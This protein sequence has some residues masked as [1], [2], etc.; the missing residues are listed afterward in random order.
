L[1]ALFITVSGLNMRLNKII[2]ENVKSFREK[3]EIDF[4]QDVNIFIGPNGGGK[5]NLMNTLYW[6]LNSRFYSPY[7][8]QVQGERAVLQVQNYGDSAPE[9]H[10]SAYDKPSYVWI[11]FLA[12]EEDVEG[13]REIYRNKDA[14]KEKF[15]DMLFWEGNQHID[16]SEVVLEY[17]KGVVDPD[18]YNMEAGDK[19]RYKISIIRE[20]R[21]QAILVA[22]DE[23]DAPIEHDRSKLYDAYLRYL[24]DSE[25]RKKLKNDKDEINLPYILFPPTRS[26]HDLSVNLSGGHNFSSMTQSY[27]AELH[28]LVLSGGGSAQILSQIASTVI[29]VKLLE[30]VYEGGLDYAIEKF[31][32]SDEFRELSEQLSVFGFKWILQSTNK[33]ANQFQILIAKM[34]EDGFFSVLQASSGEK[35]LLNFV[36]GLSSASVQN[37]LIIIDEPELNLHPRWQKLLLRFFLQ[38]QKKRN[39]Q[40]ILSTHSASFLDDTTLPHVRRIYRRDQSSALSSPHQNKDDGFSLLEAVK[41]LNAQQNERIF[42]TQKAIL[43]E[44]QSDFVV[45]QKLINSILEVFGV[46]EIIEVIEVLGSSNFQKYRSFLNLLEIENYIVADQDYVTMIGNDEVRRIFSKFFQE[47]KACQSILKNHSLDKMQ[48][49]SAIENAVENGDAETLSA[50]LEYLKCRHTKIDMEQIPDDELKV[51]DEFRDAKA[52]EGIFVLRKGALEAYYLLDKEA[53]T[54]KKDTDKAIAFAGDSKAFASWIIKGA[55][56]VKGEALTQK[57]RIMADEAAEFIRIAM[58]IVGVESSK[59]NGEKLLDWAKQY[60][61]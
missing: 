48:L 49:I 24:T 28:N 13:L 39:C 51:F 25:L 36:F 57:D 60:S 3:T 12:T 15:I 44:G 38:V 50:V 26:P 52:G 35:Q 4:S 47:N 54:I 6:V 53:G 30:F 1:N 8:F 11:E 7:I 40:F 56:V 43:V 16:K 58:R 21:L 23:N 19:F 9:P 10:W 42:F 37:S 18:A 20:R 22:V 34:H 55:R 46:G 59:E 45:W 27:R 17:E 41:L 14:L 61:V 32:K 31:N 33:W 2:L 5:S 29:G